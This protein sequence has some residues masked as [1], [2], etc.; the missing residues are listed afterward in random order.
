MTRRWKK[1]LQLWC[2]IFKDSAPKE[3]N[4]LTGFIESTR[5]GAVLCLN[6]MYANPKHVSDDDLTSIWNEVEGG[7]GICCHDA[8]GAIGC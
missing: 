5:I 2:K 8:S 6:P 4:S 1:D 3:I 7:K